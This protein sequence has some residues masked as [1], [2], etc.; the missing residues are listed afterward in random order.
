[1]RT[2]STL[3]VSLLIATAI[4]ADERFAS[5]YTN[6]NADA[7]TTADYDRA[8]LVILLGHHKQPVEQ[9]TLTTGE[10]IPLKNITALTPAGMRCITDSGLEVVPFAQMPPILTAATGWTMD[11]GLAYTEARKA[12]DRGAA[13]KA[14]TAWTQHR[15]AENALYAQT[16][17]AAV[18]AAPATRRSTGP[19]AETVAR[20]ETEAAKRW[21]QDYTM[22]AFVRKNQLQAW[23]DLALYA[24]SGV[25]HKT[26]NAIIDK[27]HK[28]W[29]PDFVM[30]LFECKQ[31]AEAYKK[32]E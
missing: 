27:A 17:A 13:A 3:L 21:P 7:A 9:V 29:W 8:A 25:P 6:R 28:E 15:A 31:Q 30:I 18:A 2:P 19:S 26:L 1:M 23:E 4:R 10:A 20:I 32:L 22:Q 5:W 11:I 14:T 16:S 12:Q 24:P